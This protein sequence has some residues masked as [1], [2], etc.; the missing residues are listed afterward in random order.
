MHP[1]GAQSFYQPPMK[2]NATLD[3]AEKP[4]TIYL[5]NMDFNLKEEDLLKIFKE[6]ELK[7][8]KLRLLL[9]DRG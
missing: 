8:L 2:G 3:E 7:V 5:A 6:Y 4:T 1:G 9:N